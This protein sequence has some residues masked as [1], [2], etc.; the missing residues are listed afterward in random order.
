LCPPIP[1]EYEIL[2][3]IPNPEK[4]MDRR[5][6]TYFG[7]AKRSVALNEWLG[8]DSHAWS[9][10][11]NCLITYHSITLI[12]NDNDEQ[13]PNIQDGV[14]TVTFDTRKGEFSFII[15]GGPFKVS[16]VEEELKSD[17]V[18]PVV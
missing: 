10:Y 5:N 4:Q 16:F 8:V 3:E 1:S 14:I 12:S 13:R 2:H 11:R 17:D 18:Y 7:V 6:S 9:L 15:N